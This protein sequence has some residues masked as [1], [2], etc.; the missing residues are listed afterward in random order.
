M[1]LS[2]MTQGKNAPLAQGKSRTQAE[3]S[4]AEDMVADPSGGCP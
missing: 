3:L 4:D 1:T 2:R